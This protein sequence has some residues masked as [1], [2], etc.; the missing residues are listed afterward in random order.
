MKVRFTLCLILVFGLTNLASAQYV[1]DST[2]RPTFV[3]KIGIH[4]GSNSGMGLALGGEFKEK[5]AVILSVLP[6]GSRDQFTLL[7]GAQLDFKL[8]D[9]R[10]VDIY[11]GFNGSVWQTTREEW[12]GFEYA[13]VTNTTVNTGIAVKGDVSSPTSP[14]HF[15]F[16]VGYGVYDVQDNYLFL[17]SASVGLLVDLNL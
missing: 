1:N 15:Q 10:T 16:S 5:F 8:K 7:S 4:L 14:V 17:P 6:V 2:P 13:K 9:N 3:P 11:L 12:N